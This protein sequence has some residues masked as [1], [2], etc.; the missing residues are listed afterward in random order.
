MHIL[1]KIFVVLVTLLAVLMVPLVVVYAYNENSYEAKY[2]SAMAQAAAA[3]S[4]FESSKAAN[5]AV[6]T[7]SRINILFKGLSRA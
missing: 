3:R 6:P 4:S 7:I 1:T 2:Q 5:A